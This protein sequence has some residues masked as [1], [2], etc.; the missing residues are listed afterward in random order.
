VLSEPHPS[1]G[2]DR[3]AAFVVWVIAFGLLFGAFVVVA[4]AS[5]ERRPHFWARV[6]ALPGVPAVTTGL[7]IGVAKLALLPAWVVETALMLLVSLA[8]PALML[9][10]ALLYRRPGPPDDDNGPG[11]GPQPPPEPPAPG[12]GGDVPLP[13]AEQSR[14][15][16]R[17]HRPA[18]S[19]LRRPRRPAREPVREPARAP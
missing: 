5:R 19:A 18:V 15:R 9:A 17:D 13:D 11:R 4:G 12:P 8:V 10:P 6:V 3:V 16:L 14:R 2:A 1:A 7:L